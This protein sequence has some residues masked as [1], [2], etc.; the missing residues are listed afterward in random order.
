VH[1]SGNIFGPK[2]KADNGQSL[3]FYN[4]LIVEQKP[5]SEIRGKNSCELSGVKSEKD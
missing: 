1:A 3:L 4:V 2:V 5:K